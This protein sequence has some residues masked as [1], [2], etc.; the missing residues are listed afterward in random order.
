[1]PGCFVNLSNDVIVPRSVFD[2][3]FNRTTGLERI[4]MI[5]PLGKQLG[6]KQIENEPSKLV[7]VDERNQRQPTNG[8]EAVDV[9]R[10]KV[11]E[12]FLESFRG[13]VGTLRRLAFGEEPVA[14]R[15]AGLVHQSL[16]FE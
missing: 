15:T 13:F 14:I 9:E 4:L 10:V 8:I 6:F 16:G 11:R 1:M 7:I 3:L 2:H 12:R 5:A